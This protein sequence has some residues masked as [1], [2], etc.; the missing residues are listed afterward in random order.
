MAGYLASN[1]HTEKANQMAI[2][3]SR[4]IFFQLRVQYFG[5]PNQSGTRGFMA[6]VNGCLLDD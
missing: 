5:C 1:F 3:K 4:L 2:V 6:I